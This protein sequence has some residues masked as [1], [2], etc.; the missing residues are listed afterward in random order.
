M[1]STV[2]VGGGRSPFTMRAMI[3]STHS[4]RIVVWRVFAVIAVLAVAVYFLLLPNYV[5]GG[6]TEHTRIWNRLRQLDAA[7]ESWALEHSITE[8]VEPSREDLTPYLAEGFWDRPV[9][10]ERCIINPYGS[11]VQTVLTRQIEGYP[12]GTILELSL[13]GIV[14]EKAPNKSGQTN[15]R[16][17]SPFHAGRQ[18]GSA[19][20]APPS[21][22]AAVAHHWRS[23]F[24]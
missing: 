17:A 22:S 23:A 21:L 12:A 2:L 9:A 8:G 4:A 14:T 19:S 10:G 20:C 16:P 15:R 6:L 5:N 13:D 18:F 1:R 11:P 3:A 7:K 24:R